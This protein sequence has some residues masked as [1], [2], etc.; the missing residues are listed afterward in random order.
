MALPGETVALGTP[1]V[2]PICGVTLTMEVL[3]SAAG[4]YIGF[5]CYSM[6]KNDDAEFCY[7]PYSRESGYYRRYEEAEAAMK[8]GNFG[9]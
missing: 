7:G 6:P 4:Y 2:C 3:K 9:R 5:F 1:V 8:S